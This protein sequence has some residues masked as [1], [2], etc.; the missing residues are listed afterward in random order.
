VDTIKVLGITPNPPGTRQPIQLEGVAFDGRNLWVSG[1]NSSIVKIDLKKG[2]QHLFRMPWEW[3]YLDG[4]TW[5][6][7]HLWVVTNNSTIYEIDPCSMGMLDFFAAPSNVGGGPEGFTFDGENLWFGDNDLDKIY[8]IILKD[9]ILTALAPAGACEEGILLSPTPTALL[10]APGGERRAG[11]VQAAAFPAWG[12][13]G[14]APGIHHQ[15]AGQ[16]PTRDAL[17]RLRVL[18]LPEGR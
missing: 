12:T 9:K 18:R 8:K 3:G 5:A 1:D 13:G 15:T 6:F 2:T 11:R 10:A 16:G 4:M 7:D 14:R 17:G